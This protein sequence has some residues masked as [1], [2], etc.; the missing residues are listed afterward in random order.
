MAPTGFGKG[1]AVKH[2]YAGD[3]SR[4]YAREKMDTQARV[5]KERKAQMYGSMLKEGH[6]RGE[7]NNGRLEED[8]KRINNELADFVSENPNWESDAGLFGKFSNITDQY[9]NNPIIQEDEQVNQQY[10]VLQ[11]KFN[12]GEMRKGEMEDQMDR[13][14][15]YMQNGGDPYVFIQPEKIMYADILKDS[16]SQLVS[17]QKEVRFMTD[18]RIMG[19]RTEKRV[20]D[21]SIASRV[22]I[23][24]NDE[25]YAEEITR[26]WMLSGGLAIAP[27]AQAYHEHNLR[28]SH[29][30]TESKMTYDAVGLRQIT[31][32]LSASGEEV[33]ISQAKRNVFQP[34]WQVKDQLRTASSQA[35]KD[36]IEE[37]FNNSQVAS[38][39]NIAFTQF[40]EIG[41]KGSIYSSDDF[42]YA[43]GTKMEGSFTSVTATGAKRP[44]MKNGMYYMETDVT[45]SLPSGSSS[46]TI[47]KLLTDNGFTAFDLKGKSPSDFMVGIDITKENFTGTVLGPAIMRETNRNAYDNEYYGSTKAEE[48]ARAEGKDVERMTQIMNRLPDILQEINKA[49]PEF[50]AGERKGTNLISDDGTLRVDLMTGNIYPNE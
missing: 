14:T 27:T 11:Q 23:D 39:L 8:Y 49:Y 10:Q 19:S 43:N 44:V 41:R 1:L 9:L 20:S 40:G 21:A 5:E 15:D 42:L 48:A 38:P 32:G 2:D 25:D 34:L 13:Y 12:S 24:F 22:D 6:V 18:A 26:N 17:N 4:L 47:S 29:Q 28:A 31:A 36:A 3:I 45:I 37:Q 35:E 33:S 30:E 46:E 50:G 16:S 7:Y